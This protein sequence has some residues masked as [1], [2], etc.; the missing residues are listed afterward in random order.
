MEAHDL[1]NQVMKNIEVL[2]SRT[3]SAADAESV[4]MFDGYSASDV[5]ELI[6]ELREVS[7]DGETQN[8]F[9]D[10]DRG[11]SYLSAVN[12]LGWRRVKVASYPQ[13]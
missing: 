9:Y 1:L 8:L 12:L 13:A 4:G 3:V 11:V 7:I 5:N 6:N 2:A 10:E